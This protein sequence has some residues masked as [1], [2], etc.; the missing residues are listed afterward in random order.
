M[1][2]K[3]MLKAVEDVIM[4]GFNYEHEFCLKVWGNTNMGKH[5][6]S[7]F[8]DIYAKHGASASMFVF[9]TELDNRNRYKLVTYITTAKER[10]ALLNEILNLNSELSSLDNKLHGYVIR[11]NKLMNLCTEYTKIYGELPN[12]KG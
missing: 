9:F 6:N 11:L 1:T 3:E 2:S 5:L 10:K 8:S 12:L 4:Y 7:K